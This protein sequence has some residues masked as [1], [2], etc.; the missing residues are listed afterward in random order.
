MIQFNSTYLTMKKR[1]LVDSNETLTF[2]S[3]SNPVDTIAL[4]QHLNNSYC[5]MKDHSNF[6]LSL[7]PCSLNLLEPKLF[8]SHFSE[9]GV[10][11]FCCC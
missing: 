4:F 11:Y 10:C 3:C 2:D 6:D 9:I 5:D 8:E 1:M 7:S